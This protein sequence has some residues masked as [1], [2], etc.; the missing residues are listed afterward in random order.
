MGSEMCIR[1]RTIGRPYPQ[2]GWSDCSVPWLERCIYEL[3]RTRYLQIVIPLSICRDMAV[4]REVLYTGL[5]WPARPRRTGEAFLRH[6][7]G[8]ESDPMTM[9]F[10]GVFYHTMWNI[11]AHLLFFLPPSGQERNDKVWP[12][13]LLFPPNSGDGSVTSPDFVQVQSSKNTC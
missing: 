2:N 4:A 3:S 6:R 7:K 1:D 8:L 13:F 5:S 11:V 12:T 10:C 9:K